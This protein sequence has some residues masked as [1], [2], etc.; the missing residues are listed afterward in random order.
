MDRTITVVWDSLDL[1]LESGH[2]DAM[3]GCS[4]H[5]FDDENN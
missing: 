3:K 5:S 4:Q 2:V 1:R